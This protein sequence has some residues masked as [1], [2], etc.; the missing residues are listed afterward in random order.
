MERT[1]T[2]ADGQ[3]LTIRTATRADIDGLR[4]LYDS[5]S[6][7]DRYHRFFG[8]ARPTPAAIA[9]W[10]G[11]DETGA[12]HTLVAVLGD[13]PGRIVGEAGYVLLPNGNGELGITVARD[14]RGWLGPY[15][16]HALAD[17]AAARGVPNLEAEILVDNE[18]MRSLLVRRGCVMVDETRGSTVRVVIGT[19]TPVGTWPPQ[20]TAPRALVEGPAPSVAQALARE[21]V[22]VL[23]C[24]GP[25]PRRPTCPLLAGAPCPV[26]RDA[27]VIVVALGRADPTTEPILQG[28]HDLAPGVPVCVLDTATLATPEGRKEALDDVQR[29]L[30]QG[31]EE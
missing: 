28:H 9:R 2:L 30:R 15:L 3:V 29:A 22:E 4:Q 19:T 24:P 13:Q 18:A 6:L 26:A 21:G 20:H 25:G 27:D 8:A 7:D 14:Q 17:D 1:T 12:G 11:L 23:R 16:L 10:A 5:L 31:D